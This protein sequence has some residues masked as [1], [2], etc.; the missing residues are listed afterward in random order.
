MQ[1]GLDHA[2]SE[3]QKGFDGLFENM[4]VPGLS[5]LLKGPIA[6]W[7]RINPIGTP[8]EDWLGSKVAEAMQ[9]PGTLRDRHT[10][11]IH[12]SDD[13][14]DGLGRLERALSLTAD[15]EPIERRLRDAVKAGKIQKASPAK[16]IEQALA[17]HVITADE[18]VRL[19]EAESARYAAI[20]VDSFT[21][22]EYGG[23]DTPENVHPDFSKSGDGSTSEM[24]GPQKV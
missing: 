13:P 11:G 14:N 2:F 10:T 3:M 24:A 5:L 20:E 16:L 23:I 1:W 17:A 9:T 8:P 21:L 18:A 15:T 6:L 12:V 22:E 4:E 7:S 19:Q